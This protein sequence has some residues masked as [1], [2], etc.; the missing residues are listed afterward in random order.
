MTN[1]PTRDVRD[2]LLRQWDTVWLDPCD[3]TWI[4]FG[5]LFLLHNFKWHRDRISPERW[6]GM[7]LITGTNAWNFYNN[8]FA[9]EFD[10]EGEPYVRRDRDD[11]HGDRDRDREI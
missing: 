5:E 10:E 8:L 4:R 3:E 7:C 1:E 2:D 11:P 6:R 9:L